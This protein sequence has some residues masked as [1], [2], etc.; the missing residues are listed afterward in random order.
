MDV[1]DG[2]EVTDIDSAARQQFDIPRDIR[3]A[4]VYSVAPDS[5]A[6]EAGLRPGDVILEIN[7]QSVRN[8]DQAVALSEKVAGESVLSRVW[9]AG[10][11]GRPG[12]THYLVV[13][14]TK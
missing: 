10:T 11:G 7:R 1:L 14:N 9:S 2:V 5:S 3:G 12:G 6:A 13:Q 4:L 8:A